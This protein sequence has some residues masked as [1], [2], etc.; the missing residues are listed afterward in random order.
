MIRALARLAIRT[1]AAAGITASAAAVA[2]PLSWA[3][4][5]I[6]IAYADAPAPEL[7]QHWSQSIHTA[8]ADEVT[9]A[10]LNGLTIAAIVL[11]SLWVAER[12]AAAIDTYRGVE[13]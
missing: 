3:F 12:I 1:V 4:D 8:T 7:W 2:W 6:V 10:V 11:A 13:L 5:R 9:I